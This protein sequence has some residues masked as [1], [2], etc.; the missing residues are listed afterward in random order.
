MWRPDAPLVSL[1][2]R[3]PA[4]PVRVQLVEEL[5]AALLFVAFAYAC[6]RRPQAVERAQKTAV[7]LVLPPHVPR[8]A[9]SRGAQRVEPAVVADAEVGVRLDVRSGRRRQFPQRGTPGEE[10]GPP[11]EHRRDPLR[12]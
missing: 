9:P 10:P 6:R 11:R 8:A 3:L 5:L 12:G 7:R 2:R 1:L 4:V